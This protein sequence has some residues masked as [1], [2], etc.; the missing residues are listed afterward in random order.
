MEG[1]IC[2]VRHGSGRAIDFVFGGIMG[3][4]E[5]GFGGDPHGIQAASR[6]PAE[7]FT[8]RLC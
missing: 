2:R 4:S 5:A 1:I 6:H 8:E 7:N 3:N